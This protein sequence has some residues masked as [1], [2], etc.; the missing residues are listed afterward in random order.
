M[1]FSYAARNANSEKVSGTVEASDDIDAMKKLE[2]AGLTPSSLEAV[3]GTDLGTTSPDCGI[4][5]PPSSRF[6]TDVPKPALSFSQ[7]VLLFFWW[8][9]LA[10]VLVKL[11]AYFIA[12]Q[13]PST[14]GGHA[15]AILRTYTVF[16]VT[17]S[18]VGFL[19]AQFFQKKK[20]MF[21]VVFATLFASA[22]LLN[23]PT[24]ILLRYSYSKTHKE[25]VKWYR[26]AIEQ[27]DGKAQN[28]LG[29]MYYKGGGVR[30]D[31][32]ESYAWA[33]LAASNGERALLDSGV[34]GKELRPHAQARAK[35]IAAE[36][37]RKSRK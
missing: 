8:I 2:H 6:Q 17:L 7:S 20:R 23:L 4:S 30:Q 13:P 24:A 36:I 18:G 21:R 16:G 10:A 29:F 11:A 28:N 31:D 14:P 19:V 32:I 5:P 33:I 1:L 37:E 34:L 35:E 12:P 15:G 27:G 22:C 25:A 3:N 26:K 9:I